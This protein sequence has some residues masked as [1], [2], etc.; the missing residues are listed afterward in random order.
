[1]VHKSARVNWHHLNDDKFELSISSS[2]TVDSLMQKLEAANGGPLEA[3]SHSV[4][5][6]GQVLPSGQPLANYGVGKGS[7]LELVPHEPVMCADSDQLPDGSPS[8]A[9]PAHQLHDNWQRARAGLAEGCTPRLAKAGTGGSYFLQDV[10]GNSVA[11]FKPEDEEP[12]AINNPKGRTPGS[13]SDGSASS[14]EGLRR[15]TRPG[16]GAVREVAAY[17]LDHDHFAGVPP[18]ALVSC[19]VNQPTGGAVKVGSLQQFVD[20]EGDCE[21]RGT[22]HFPINE[23]QKIAVLDMRL[24]N[25]DRNGG[26]IL[27]RRTESGEWNLIPIDHGYCLP[28]SFEDISFEW[29]YWPQAEQPFDEATLAYIEALDAEH[30]LSILA[31]HGLTFRSECL[32][33]FRVCTMLLKKGAAAGLTPYQIASIMCRQGLGKSALEKLHANALVL[34]AATSGAG[35][36]VPAGSRLSELSGLE[37]REYYHQMELLLGQYLEEFL[38]EGEDLLY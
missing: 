28:A 37:Q 25:T 19:F 24:A 3:G 27:A 5:F 15:G 7:V 9:S 2:D 23:V 38:L 1:M 4:L 18:T 36:R 22:S 17:L 13:S 12:L 31:A 6:D 11:V 32:R 34:A 26:N 8:L 30:D 10:E 21:E 29:M 35:N 16:E 14:G 20:S 33:V